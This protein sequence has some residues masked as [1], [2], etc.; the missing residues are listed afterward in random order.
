[1]Q[2]ASVVCHHRSRSGGSGRGRTADTRIFNPLLYQLSY[3]AICVVENEA[4]IMPDEAGVRKRI[5]EGLQQSNF[6]GLLALHCHHETI[7]RSCTERQPS[8]LPLPRRNAERRPGQVPSTPRLCSS[9]STRWRWLHRR[10][11]VPPQRRDDVK[12]LDKDGDGRISLAE[13]LAAMG[14]RPASPGSKTQSMRVPEGVE[15]KRDIAYAETDNP[16]Q[17]LD[18]YL[19]HRNATA[20]SRCQSWCSSMVAAGRGAT[21]QAACATSRLT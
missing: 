21:S 13:H 16:R 4:R 3:R 10:Q 19:P 1:M 9:G 8:L 5:L 20:T 12:R 18:L 2:N 17:K 7:R 11:E 14:A 6:N 15:G